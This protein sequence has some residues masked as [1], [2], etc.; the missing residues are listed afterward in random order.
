MKMQRGWKRDGMNNIGMGDDVHAVYDV[1]SRTE[2]INISTTSYCILIERS[3]N[4]RNNIVRL[5]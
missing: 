4:I 5:Q 2:S 3:I 1:F